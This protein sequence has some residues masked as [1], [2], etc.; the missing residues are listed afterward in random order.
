[1][2]DYPRQEFVSDNDI[3]VD[4]LSWIGFYAKT[5]HELAL[6]L[7][8]ESNSKKFLEITN[9][10]K[11]NL[12][13]YHWSEENKMFCDAILN[14]KGNVEQHV[15]HVGYISLFP[16][17]HGLIDE[18]SVQT[19]RTLELIKDPEQLWTSFGIRSL[20]AEHGLYGQ[21]ENYWRGPIWINMNYLILRALKEYYMT[22]SCK[23]KEEAARVYEELRTNVVTNI[24]KVSFTCL[25][26][27]FV[28]IRENRIYVG[29]I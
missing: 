11:G 2:D 17:L 5:L 20:S 18:N 25:S 21:G 22:P 9:Q 7:D 13:K 19:K 28:G 6:L 8:D 27:C 26:N 4:L 3:H 16:F 12:V 24:L 10:I 29:A 23:F 1:L 14:D 15:C